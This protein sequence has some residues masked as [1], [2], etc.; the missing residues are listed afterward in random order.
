VGRLIA[1]DVVLGTSSGKGFVH[2]IIGAY[3]PWNPGIDDGEFW[4]QVAKVCHGLQHSWLLARD[5]NATL[6][7]V[8]QLSGGTDMRRLFTRFLQ[9]A[10]GL[11]LWENRVDRNWE[12]DWTCRACGSSTGGNIIDRV[13]MSHADFSDGEIHVAEKDL[14]PELTTE[15]SYVSLTLNPPRI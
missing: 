14:Y 7:L 6:S 11:D 3:A 13:V 1:V 15:P 2:R 5:L 4:T 10:N 9:E 12:R 8:E